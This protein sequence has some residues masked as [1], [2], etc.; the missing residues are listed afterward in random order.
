MGRKRIKR[1]GKKEDQKR[2]EE[3]GLKEMGRK[4]IKRDG[5]KED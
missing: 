3:R 2:W 5:K 1:D 4:R